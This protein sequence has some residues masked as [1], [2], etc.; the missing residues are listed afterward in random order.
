[1]QSPE[2]QASA[3]QPGIEIFDAEGQASTSGRRAGRSV[4]EAR[5]AV[6]QLGQHCPTMAGHSQRTDRAEQ[7]ATGLTCTPEA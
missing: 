4:F 1:M 5:E 6:A 2:P 3:R 7:A